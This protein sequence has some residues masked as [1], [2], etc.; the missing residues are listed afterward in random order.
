MKRYSVTVVDK[1]GLE[2]NFEFDSASDAYRCFADAVSNIELNRWGIFEYVSLFDNRQ[3]KILSF[4]S[5][6]DDLD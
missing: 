5:I 1:D 6:W 4:Y 3:L 2:I